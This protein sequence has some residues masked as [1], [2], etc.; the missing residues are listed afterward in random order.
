[1]ETVW[2]HRA[3]P[4]K[5]P[6]ANPRSEDDE[7]DEFDPAPAGK[8]RKQ[9]KQRGPYPAAIARLI[10]SATSAYI[11]S[12]LPRAV[13]S[14]TEVNPISS[15][16]LRSLYSSRSF[17]ERLTYRILT[18]ILVL[19]MRTSWVTRSVRSNFT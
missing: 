15:F 13:R 11:S 10:G 7:V 5:A 8:G 14:C 17:G 19:S 2:N 16:Y 9:K 4:C 3:H 1:M 12:D 18:P 6:H